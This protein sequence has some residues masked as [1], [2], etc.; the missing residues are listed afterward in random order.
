MRSARRLTGGIAAL[1]L[2]ILAATAQGRIA[3][4]PCVEARPCPPG[5]AK[6][7][8]AHRHAAAP[9]ARAAARVRARARKASGTLLAPCDDPPDSLCGSIDVPLDRSQPAGP[10]TPVFFSVIP[11]SGSGPVAGTILASAGGPGFSSSAEGFF[12]FLFGPLLDHRDL[13]TIDLR[14]TGRSAPIDCAALQHG[15]GALLDAIGE[16]GAQLGAAASRFGSADRAEDIEDVRAALGIPK[17]DYFGLSGGGLQAQAYAVR[18]G[19]RLRT[20][21]LDAPY[22][23][24]FD[25]AFQSPSVTALLRG[26]ELICRRSPSCDAADPRPLRTLRRLIA[27]VR[28]HPVAGTALGAD[29]E[30]HRVVVDETRLVNLLADPSGGFL[31]LSEI[32]AAGRALQRGDA[33]PLLRMAAET[34]FPSFFDAGDP[35]FFSAGDFYATF[36]ADG[37]FPWDEGAPEPTRR[38]QYDAAVAALPRSAFA[39]FS[40]GAWERSL[41]A[42]ADICVPWPARTHVEPPIPAGARFPAVPTLVLT[43]DLDAA[44]P[45]ESA[46]AVARR[47]PR[48]QLVTV[49]NAGHTATPELRLRARACRPV[50]RLGRAGRCGLRRAVQPD[51]RRRRLPARRRARQDAG[52]RPRGRRPVPP[53]RPPRGGDGVGRRLRRD[54]ALVPHVRRPRRRA[55]RRLVLARRHGHDARPLL[56]PGAV[57][58]RRRGRR[59]GAHRLRDREGRRG[60]RGRRPGGAGRQAANR[61]P[62]VPAHGPAAR[63]RRDRRAPHR[64]RR[65]DRMTRVRHSRRVTGM[66]W[67]CLLLAAALAGCGGGSS[68]K[69]QRVTEGAVV[70]RDGLDDNGGGWLLVDK[71]VRFRKGVYE[72]QEVPRGGASAASD[73]ML[74]KPI[75][76]GLAVS[77]VTELRAGAALRAVTCRETGPRELPRRSGTSSVSTGGVP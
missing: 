63:P 75:P 69:P 17:L 36:C 71:L 18:H 51:L 45:S 65:P 49:A 76:A 4:A 46:R 64:D 20:L 74:R 19:D 41:V 37:S 26:V 57:H 54:P 13:L 44:V 16:C 25:D 30:T 32:S 5:A 73:V 62:A 8:R 38:R 53:A 12:P 22:R 42:T 66:R 31:D 15:E 29:G 50:R 24:G 11:H 28:R 23:V 48:A 6:L 61:R 47:F 35:R 52:R 59:D 77:V 10:T 67:V 72:W 70:Y 58:P 2:L 7:M 34:D 68:S 1:M 27:T 3:P 40:V 14:G 39:P 43:G 60:P 21:V 33:A 55:A 9:S 56:R